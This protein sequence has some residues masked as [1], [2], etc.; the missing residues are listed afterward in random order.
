MP[1][2][3]QDSM[4]DWSDPMNSFKEELRKFTASENNLENYSVFS[5]ELY[6]YKEKY[7][8]EKFRIQP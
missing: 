3:N 1:K 4:V 7:Y 5:H 2:A 6:S 8:R